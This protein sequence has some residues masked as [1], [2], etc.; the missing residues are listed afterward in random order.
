MEDSKTV[1]SSPKNA[2]KPSTSQIIATTLAEV[3]GNIV[4]STSQRNSSNLSKEVNWGGDNQQAQS[5]DENQAPDLSNLSIGDLLKR[6]GGTKNSNKR[7]SGK[8]GLV[9]QTFLPKPML[10]LSTSANAT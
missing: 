8:K 7:K 2:E 4:V 6:R 5:D 10:I 9:L 3:N 1:S